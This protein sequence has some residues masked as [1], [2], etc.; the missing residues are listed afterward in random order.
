MVDLV[1]MDNA[2]GIESPYVSTIDVFTDRGSL[3]H[4]LAGFLAAY[5]G[6][7]WAVGISA[8]FGGYELGKLNA[9]EPVTRVA[10]TLIE[11]GLGALLAAL[12]AWGVRHG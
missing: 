1:A 5:V 6:N 4:V 7:G 11:F 8:A 10:G 12:L 2:I 9:G 3:V